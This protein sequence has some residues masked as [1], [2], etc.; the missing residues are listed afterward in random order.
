MFSALVAAL[1]DAIQAVREGEIVPPQAA[2]Q[3]IANMYTWDNVARRTEKVSLS[4]Y[5]SQSSDP[6]IG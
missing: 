3:R 6:Q 1:E 5:L 4:L 2:H